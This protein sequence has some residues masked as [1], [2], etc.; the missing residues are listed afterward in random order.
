MRKVLGLYQTSVGKKVVMAVSG[1]LLYG[2]VV[3]H[4]IGNLK[5]YYGREK[6]NAYAEFL[7]S[8]GYPALG[9]EQAL[10]IFRIVLIAAVGVHLLAATQLT[11]RSWAARPA[12]YR[13]RDDLSFS[14]ASRTMRWGGV[15]V[16]LFVIYHLLH[17]TFGTVHPHFEPGDVYANVVSGFR[18]WP[19]A[20]AYILCMIPLGWHMYHGLWSLTQ[21]LAIENPVVKRWRRPVAAVIAVV[22]IAGNISIPLAVLTGI[23]H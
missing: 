19:V 15:I 12:G 17:L 1:I 2:F 13:R 20:V 9:H 10:W 11:L 23:V 5:V 18:V 8:I 4:M 22:T 16:A 6:Y 7:R 21:T 3:V 14:Y